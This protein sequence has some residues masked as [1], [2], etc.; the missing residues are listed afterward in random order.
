MAISVADNFLYQGKKPLDARIV[1]NTLTDM[2]NMPAT[3]IYDGCL[4]YVKSEKKYY[5]FDSTNTVDPT[6]GK[7]KELETGGGDADNIVEGYFNA[8]DNLFYEENTYTT[9]ITGEAGKIYVALD[10]N[11]TYRF[12]GTIFVR[13]DEE[14]FEN[15]QYTTMP[16]ASAS[17]VGQIVQYIGETTTVAPIYVKGLFYE[18]VE[19]TS[20]TP[21]TY[22]WVETKVQSEIT[23]FDELDNRPV[24]N[25]TS[26]AS[27]ISPTPVE[28]TSK[29]SEKN[30]IL[31]YDGKVFAWMNKNNIVMYVNS[32][33]G[34]DN[35]DGGYGFSADKPFKSI[36]YAFNYI[37]T[38][39]V[40]MTNYYYDAPVINLYV[41]GTFSANSFTQ[42][43]IRHGLPIYITLT[44]DTVFNNMGFRI[45]SN[46]CCIINLDQY[47]LTMNYTLTTL[48]SSINSFICTNMSHLHIYGTGKLTINGNSDLKAI[49][50]LVTVTCAG[51][52]SLSILCPMEVNTL[53]RVFNLN[54][55]GMIYIENCAGSNN[56][57]L[58]YAAQG[59]VFSY[60]T[61]TADGNKR[62]MTGGRIFT[63]SQT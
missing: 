13:L 37:P 31:F 34:V 1:F 22:S 24:K 4:A 52:S 5:T 42:F 38:I 55:N 23:E 12:N 50:Y 60:N 25:V 3:V 36:G 33:T 43:R 14:I 28:T 57:D 41:Q 20:T 39:G 63:G 29:W 19:D 61:I 9:A 56:I 58:I 17:N 48:S 45:E 44:G 16:A 30:G 8:T 6:I 51:G 15:I 27:L 26:I 49:T 7:W 2:T 46:Q 47:N 35:F 62:T 54:T 10:T 59:G 40:E 32:E 11:K 21:S 18:V 53:K